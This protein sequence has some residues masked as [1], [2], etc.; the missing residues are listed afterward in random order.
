MLALLATACASSAGGRSDET[1][2]DSA[3][4]TPVSPPDPTPT[5][6]EQ[7]DSDG[8][9]EAT[10]GGGD[11]ERIAIQ[12]EASTLLTVRPD[13]SEPIPLSPDDNR[14][15]QQP[16][17][18]PDGSRIAWTSVEAESGTTALAASRFDGTGAYETETEGAASAL[19]WDPSSSQLAY[20]ASVPIGLRLAT[21]DIASQLPELPIDSGQPYWF[22]WGPG[23]DELFVHASGFRLD[24]VALDG[25]TV[26]IDSEAGEFQAPVWV[27]AE[28]SLL[29]ADSVDGV[30]TLVSTGDQG[31]GRL[32]IATFDGYLQF[33]VNPDS[34]QVAMQ[35][36]DEPPAAIPDVITASFQP[37]E[38]I[39]P[40]D[41]LP[42]D[43]L[44]V[45]AV[46]GGAPFVIDTAPADAFFWSADGGTLAYLVQV[47]AGEEPWYEWRF[48]RAATGSTVTSP[49]FRPTSVFL[50]V[51]VPAF[52][53]YATDVQFFSPAGDQFVYT[54]EA[55][56]GEDG[57]WVFAL[58]GDGDPELIA[59]GELATW[60]PGPAGGSASIIP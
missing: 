44:F 14:L 23:G 3:G 53:Q 4:P 52:D 48:F 8:D 32:P 26:V 31:E 9:E 20:V 7:S 13:G 57:V 56:T 29:F 17:W 60:S 46:Y 45:M 37:D 22:A 58:D 19:A 55:L 21:V 47:T 1:A 34:N 27:D 15:H 28:R 42:R 39:D 54:G 40:V 43:L 11:S 41:Q 51:Y 30:D 38:P 12:T 5:P 18:A 59:D 33:V 16:T 10:T 35:V 36:R 25:T 24:R 50:D 49:L 2:D 6:V